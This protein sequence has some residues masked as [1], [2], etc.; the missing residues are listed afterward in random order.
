MSQ[1]NVGSQ[2]WYSPRCVSFAPGANTIGN[3]FCAT[4][5]TLTGTLT[6]ASDST[7]VFS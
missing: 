1:S 7:V 5:L 6:T 4:Q 3:S 2:L